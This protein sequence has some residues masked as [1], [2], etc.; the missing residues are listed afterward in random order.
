MPQQI[1]PYR[2][3]GPLSRG[4]MG[5]VYRA[6]HVERGTPAAV[7]TVALPRRDL[8]LA[9]RREIHALSRVRHPG[10]VRILDEGVYDGLPWLA[11]ELL[12]GV[13][14]LQECRGSMPERVAF[15]RKVIPRLC[16]TLA[17]LHGEGLVHGDLKPANILLVAASGERLAAPWKPVLVDFG[18]ASRF[19]GGSSREKLD[20]EVE[21]YGTTAYLSP[22]QCAGEPFD[23]RADLYALGCIMYEALTGAPPFEGG[24]V[25]LLWQHGWVVPPP[26][27]QRA[28]GVPAELDALVLRLLAKRPQDRLGHADD[29]AAA[30]GWDGSPELPRPRPYLYRPRLAGRAAALAELRR[31]LDRLGAGAGGLVLLAGEAGAGKTRLAAELAREARRSSV[32]VLAGDCAPAGAPQADAGAFA[33]S[34]EPL[35]PVLQAIVDRCRERGAEETRRL[36]GIRGPVLALYEPAVA[37]LPGLEASGPPVELAPPLARLRLYSFL[38]QTLAAHCDAESGGSP[39]LLVL[40]DLHLADELTLG[41]LES[42]GKTGRLDRMPMLVIGTVRTENSGSGTMPDRLRPLAQL[43]QTFVLQLGAL[44]RAAASAVVSDMLA[45]EPPPEGLV[46]ALLRRTGGNPYS[47]AE[48]LHAAVEAGLLLRDRTGLWRVQPLEAEADEERLFEA[49][50]QPASLRELAE[51]RFHGLS[52]DAGRLTAAAA[53]AGRQPSWV[54]VWKLARLD[55]PQLFDAMAEAL[56]RGLLEEPDPEHVR[57]ASEA[58]RVAAYER[59]VAEQRRELHRR[60]AEGLE[61]LLAGGAESRWEE[62]GGHWEAAEETELARRAYLAGARRARARSALAE[63]ERL[64]RA[65]LRLTQTVTAEA[66]WA[67]HELGF[68]VLQALGRNLEALEEHRQALEQARALGD[69]QAE[70]ASLRGLGN[71]CRLTGRTEQARAYHQQALAV[72]QAAGDRQGE[73]RSLNNLALLHA[74]QGRLHEAEAL[75]HQALDVLQE[76]GDPA[77]EGIVLG[78]LALVLRQTGRPQEARRLFEEALA[79]KRRVGDRREEG[80]TLGNLANLELGLGRL[81]EALTRY[82]QALAIQREVGDRRGEGITVG[83]LGALHHEAGRPEE[84]RGLLDTA[85]EMA[86][87]VADRRLEGAVRVS[88]ARFARQTGRPAEADA[89]LVRGERLLREVRD[90]ASLISA[91]CEQGHRALSA[92]SSAET[93]AK[94]ARDLAWG[95]DLAE[96]TEGVRALGRL[97]RAQRVFEAGGRLWHGERPEDLPEGLRRWLEY[98][99]QLSASGRAD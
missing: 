96:D 74:E 68:D 66:V 35:R 86:R 89:D 92:G 8:L 30:L 80:I 11:M 40:D 84:A 10:I 65:S 36:F 20:V 64:Y 3:L 5:V 26:P 75:W 82:E 77:A 76:L 1:G 23:A 51:R 12:D 61:S 94:R 4:G 14:L 27:S 59:I 97:E 83:N 34:L 71:A 81:E 18:V 17:Y 31:P 99:G 88:R 37:A 24:Q 6:E 46:R 43:P 54:L 47:L 72:A 63:A 58:L 13:P 53:V 16:L 42:L 39:L 52:E 41:F 98:A 62:L 49:L 55:V 79:L 19:S 29:V 9:I 25:Q 44:D 48:H 85:V 91:L 73:H 93:F 22:E 2:L 67:R 70:A 38:V 95:L 69:R 21:Q 50:P 32:A 90:Q 60:A 7:K 57:F 45:L 56:Q 87:E 78:N 15:V 28:P 33:A